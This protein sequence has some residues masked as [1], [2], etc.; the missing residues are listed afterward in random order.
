MSEIVSLYY[1]WEFLSFTASLALLY[2]LVY[3]NVMFERVGGLFLLITLS[4]F[5]CL[6]CPRNSCRFDL[7]YSCSCDMDYCRAHYVNKMSFL[8]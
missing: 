4:Y 2:V 3:L 8:S 7:E 5:N 6:L 1:F